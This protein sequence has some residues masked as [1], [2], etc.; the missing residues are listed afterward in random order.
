MKYSISLLIFGLLSCSGNNST[1]PFN[2]GQCCIIEYSGESVQDKCYVNLNMDECESIYESLEVEVIGMSYTSEN[3]SEI[4]ADE[5][6]E[7]CSD[8]FVGDYVESGE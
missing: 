5:W 3:C 7:D 2:T 4:I 6:T 8:K 1:K